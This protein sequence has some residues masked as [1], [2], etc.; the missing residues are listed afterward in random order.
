MQ[1]LTISIP[2]FPPFK[3]RSSLIDKD[4]VIWE[5][6]LADYI[7]LFRKLLALSKANSSNA[8]S[9]NIK[10]SVKTN[11][12]LIQFIQSY[13][14]EIASESNQVFSLGAINP[15]IRQNQ[16][17]LKLAVFA[18]IK[19]IN[20]V[21]LRLQ[22]KSTWDFCKTY[23]PLANKCK[24]QGINQAFLTIEQ[25]RA[26][27]EGSIKSQI[28]SK[29]D[30]VSLIRSLQDYLGKLVSSGKWKID[31]SETLYLLVGQKTKKNTSNKS[32][33]SNKIKISNGKGSD[34]SEKFV[35]KHL[36]EIF[37]EIYS[38]GKGIYSTLCLQLMSLSLCALTTHKVIALL[39]IL[40]ANTLKQLKKLYPLIAKIVLSKKFND[41]NPDLKDLMAF[42]RQ[43]DIV[44][45][46][47]IFDDSK[48]QNIESFFPQLSVAQIKTLLV[49]HNNDVEKIINYLLENSGEIN[50]I[51]KFKDIKQ[52]QNSRKSKASNIVNMKLN[53]KE[54]Q[55]QFGKKEEATSFDS[56]DNDNQQ[57]LKSKTL[58]T[59]A[60]L[61]DPNEDEPDDTYASNE[62][63]SGENQQQQQQQQ[64]QI[65]KTENALFAVYK[66]NRDALTVDARKSDQRNN[67]KREIGWSDAQIEG[68]AR[69]IDKNPRRFRELEERSVID[70]SLNSGKGLKNRSKWRAAKAED[71]SDEDDDN[72]NRRGGKKYGDDGRRIYSANDK[73]K[74]GKTPIKNTD[75]G[76][77]LN[78]NVSK[79]VKEESS[80]NFKQYMDKKDKQFK[81]KN[82]SKFSNHNRKNGSANKSK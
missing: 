57:T 60:L 46:A 17:L 14:T 55:V 34:F 39:K 64:Q 51:K 12:Q 35:D 30:D 44:K 82:K 67:L 6:L 70:G 81:E 20:L 58:Q 9:L 53:D 49:D 32:F 40:D 72:N 29:S 13:L 8:T 43:K 61:Y 5:Y 42:M 21:N 66:F 59:L 47:R 65:N 26:L 10:L 27:V 22:G 19:Q 4:P 2:S 63:T 3:L 75:L 62:I 18:Y 23:L 56:L 31:D 24:E 33:Q 68:W 11:N 28:G 15:N 16:H 25:I 45:K 76:T 79:N 74:G 71:N 38:N 80:E 69:M 1:E 48:I 41:L 36:V 50:S 7:T 78:S 77:S 54:V 73:R 37:E 52:R